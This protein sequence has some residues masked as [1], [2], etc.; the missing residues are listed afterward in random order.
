MQRLYTQLILYHLKNWQQMVFIEGPRQAGKTTI[1][2]EVIKN[3]D[4]SLYLNW[5]NV[6]D[7]LLML[8]GQHFVKNTKLFTEASSKT[9]IIVFDEIHKMPDWKNYLKGFFDLYKNKLKIIATGSSK[10]AIYKKGQDSLMGRYFNYS[11]HPLSVGELLRQDYKVGMDIALSEIVN[12]N[13]FQSLFNFSGFPEPFVKSNNNFYK[14]WSGLRQQQLFREDINVVEDIKNIQ[15]LETLAYLLQE[16]ATS[17][18]NYSRLSKKIQV[19]DQTIRKWINMLEDFYFGFTIRPWHNNV[20]R[21]ITKE[22]KFYLTDW[23]CI[24]DFGKKA[25]NFVACHL[26]K[27]IH[28]WNESGLGEYGL[29]Y[30]RD[31]EKREVDFVVTKNQKVWFLVE[32]KSSN[33]VS[34]NNLN[35]NLSYF[36]SITGANHAFQVVLDMPDKR[37]NCFDFTEPVKVPLKTFL[38]QIP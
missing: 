10:L 38:S 35:K 28:F 36:Q 23:S 31:K 33:N 26:K 2:Q 9:P 3:F 32:V 15:L 12:E 24:Y 4:V 27:A 11:I 5:D 16:E 1:A 7:R 29:H 14:R 34:L 37:I 8:Q 19:S 25:E 13:L 30:L 17:Q 6:E 20:T 21:S 18:L 22:P